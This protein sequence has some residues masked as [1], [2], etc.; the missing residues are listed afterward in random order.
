ERKLAN[1]AKVDPQVI[2]TANIGCMMQLQAGTTAPFV[3]T[4]EMLDW[5]TGGPPPDA[6]GP[7][8]DSGHPIEALVELARQTAL[9]E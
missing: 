3:H 8:K 9:V 5:A 6:L 1:I 4:V 2:V 7:L